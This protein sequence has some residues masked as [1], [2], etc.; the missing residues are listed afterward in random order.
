MSACRLRRLSCRRRRRCRPHRSLGNCRSTRRSR[1]RSGGWP[2][3]PWPSEAPAR[4]S[5]AEPA[6]IRTPSRL[7]Q[8]WRCSARLTPAGGRQS[9]ALDG[10]DHREPGCRA[11]LRCGR[12][13]T[14]QQDAHPI[15]IHLVQFEII[16]RE[17][18]AGVIRPPEAWE[19]GTKDTV[20]AYPGRDHSRESDVRSAGNSCGIATSSSTRTTR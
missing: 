12:S 14:S 9:A 13:T 15:H 11:R 20:I 16:G 1:R 18:A 10:R 7:V 19:T 8:R 4:E 3:G 17:D 5:E 6:T 2:P